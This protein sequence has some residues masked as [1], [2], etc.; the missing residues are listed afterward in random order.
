MLE[1]IYNYAHDLGCDFIAL[2]SEKDNITAQRFYE[3]LG[4]EKEVGYIKLISK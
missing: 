2:L 1:Y 4:Y 3:N